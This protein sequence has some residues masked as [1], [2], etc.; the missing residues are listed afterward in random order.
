MTYIFD[1]T[2]ARNFVDAEYPD[3]EKKFPYVGET[4]WE[5]LDIV[6]GWRSGKRPTVPDEMPKLLIAE[7]PRKTWPDSFITTN[8]LLVVR[9]TVRKVIDHLD[10]GIHQF[11]PIRFQT[12]R[13]LEIEGP[14]LAMNVTAKQDSVLV[15]KSRV[16]VNP[17]SPDTLCAFSTASRTENVFVD[18]SRQSG[19][20]LWRERRF[21]MSLLG[22]DRLAEELKAQKLRF[23]PRSFRATDI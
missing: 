19:I 4:Q 23:F 12:K 1:P 16:L 10:P 9:D 17:D 6:D 22:S 20:N 8:G 15:E 13:K 18:P 11:F 5:T 3:W 2:S 7:K 14:W 21:P